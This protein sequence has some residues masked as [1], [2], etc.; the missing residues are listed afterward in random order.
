MNSDEFEQ[1]KGK[2]SLGSQEGLNQ[3][4]VCPVCGYCPHCG[5]VNEQVPYQPIYPNWMYWSR[6]HYTTTPSNLPQRL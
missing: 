5:R 1:T 2:A 6:S 3:K 4:T